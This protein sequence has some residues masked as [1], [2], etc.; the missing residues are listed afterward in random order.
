MEERIRKAIGEA[1]V[2]A[3]APETTF[4]VERPSDPAHGDYATNA[5]LAAAKALGRKPREFAD[6][7]ARFLIEKLGKDIASHITVAG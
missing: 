6:E 1:F 4:A 7:L 3:G 2:Q 5:A